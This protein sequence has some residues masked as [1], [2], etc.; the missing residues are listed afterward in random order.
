MQR[1]KTDLVENGFAFNINTA[2]FAKLQV[3][4]D[5]RHRRQIRWQCLDWP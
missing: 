1:Y 5:T 4:V 3:E 2:G